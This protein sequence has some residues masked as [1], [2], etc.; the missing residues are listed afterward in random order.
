MKLNPIVE[1]PVHSRFSVKVA[2]AFGAMPHP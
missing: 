1:T 2:A